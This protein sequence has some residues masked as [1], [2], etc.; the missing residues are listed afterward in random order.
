MKEKTHNEVAQLSEQMPSF[1]EHSAENN[2]NILCSPHTHLKT[3]QTSST[4]HATEENY[5]YGGF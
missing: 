1:L 2:T 4:I 5:E 3:E